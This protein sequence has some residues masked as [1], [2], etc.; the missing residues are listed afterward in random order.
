MLAL[1][2]SPVK[3]I[4]S[5]SPVVLLWSVVPTSGPAVARALTACY[6]TALQAFP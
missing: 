1:G 3:E 4:V 6:N 5:A 2:A